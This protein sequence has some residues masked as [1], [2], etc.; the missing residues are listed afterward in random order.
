MRVR[1]LSYN[2]HGCIG[3]GGREDA[4]AVLEVIRRADADIVALQ[5]VQDNDDADRSFLNALDRLGYA[6]VLHGPTM[7]KPSGHYG[8]VLMS[9][10]PVISEERLDLSYPGREPRGA[11]RARLSVDGAGV[12]VLATHLG[13]GMRERRVQLQML[14]E[15]LPDWETESA[16]VVRIGMGDFNEWMPGART[17]RLLRRLFGH[18]PRVATFPA[19]FPLIA[20]DRIHVRPRS[21]LVLIGAFRGAGANR[22]SDHLPLLAE[23]R[24]PGVV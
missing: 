20:L 17:R 6:S 19:V 8:N 7:K 12:E 10:H 4:E 5:E 18:S 15:V 1:I 13:L 24:L 14:A 11:I 23:L 16:D 22:A 9:R 21:A 2:I 3:R